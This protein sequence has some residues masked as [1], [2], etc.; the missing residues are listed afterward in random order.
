MAR[1]IRA[2]NKL[3]PSDIKF[4]DLCWEQFDMGSAMSREHMW[5]LSYP[6]LLLRASFGTADSREAVEK[7]LP[8]VQQMKKLANTGELT[9]SGT[10]S[11]QAKKMANYFRTIRNHSIIILAAINQYSKQRNA[12]EALRTTVAKAIVDSH[13][14]LRITQAHDQAYLAFIKRGEVAKVMHSD[15]LQA[16]KL[17]REHL[18]HA[19]DLSLYCNK[20]ISD[21]A[22]TTLILET[23][24]EDFDTQLTECELQ[25]TKRHGA[26]G[27]MWKHY[28]MENVGVF[29]KPG[30]NYS[31]SYRAGEDKDLM[32]AYATILSCR[33][34]GQL[35]SRAI[36]NV[37]N[38][39]DGDINQIFFSTKGLTITYAAIIKIVHNA[40]QWAFGF[41]ENQHNGKNWLAKATTEYDALMALEGEARVN[42]D[43]I[44]EKGRAGDNIEKDTEQELERITAVTSI[45]MAAV[46][47][48][49]Q[50]VNAAAYLVD[51][52]VDKSL[53][54]NSECP[55]PSCGHISA[56]HA[57]INDRVICEKCGINKASVM[58]GIWVDKKDELSK[59]GNHPRDNPEQA[60][61]FPEQSKAP[62]ILPDI[63]RR[64]TPTRHV[65]INSRLYS[66]SDPDTTPTIPSTVPTGSAMKPPSPHYLGGMKI[67]NPGREFHH[68]GLYGEDGV[69]G[70]Y[71]HNISDWLRTPGRA[72]NVRA[73]EQSGGQR[74]RD[75]GSGSDQNH[76][77]DSR[78]SSQG[79][80]TNHSGNESDGGAGRHRG[81]RR[82][83]GGG[84]DGGPP[85]GRGPP[86][87]NGPQGPPDNDGESSDDED[88]G[89]NEAI[90]DTFIRSTDATADGMDGGVRSL[91]SKINAL[92]AEVIMEEQH[93]VR[94]LRAMNM[95][96]IDTSSHDTLMESPA[97]QQL[98]ENNLTTLNRLAKGLSR[99]VET[100]TDFKVDPMATDPA[101]AG[102]LM[103]RLRKVLDRASERVDYITTVTRGKDSMRARL[104]KQGESASSE[105]LKNLSDMKVVPWQRTGTHGQSF[106]LYMREFLHS[107]KIIAQTEVKFKRLKQA[108]SYET[109][110][111]TVIAT[112]D[113]LQYERALQ[114]LQSI[115]GDVRSVFVD[116]MI[117]FNKLPDAVSSQADLQRLHMAVRAFKENLKIYPQLQPR[118]HEEWFLCNI[119][120]RLSRTVQKEFMDGFSPFFADLH[121][122]DQKSWDYARFFLDVYS[123]AQLRRLREYKSLD[124]A[125]RVDM[126]QGKRQ[127]GQANGGGRANANWASGKKGR[128]NDGNP[129][130]A[131]TRTK[132]ETKKDQAKPKVK[133]NA[134]SK[135]QDT[136]KPGAGGKST[137]KA[138]AN[139][140]DQNRT[141]GKI[142]R[143]GNAK[144]NE[145]IV[146]RGNCEGFYCKLVVGARESPDKNLKAEVVKRLSNAGVCPGCGMLA[147]SG[148][149]HQCEP[150]T[151]VRRADGSEYTVNVKKAQCET[152]CNYM[153]G[154]NRV[155]LMRNLC[156][157]ARPKAKRRWIVGVIH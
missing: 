124:A 24:G 105:A 120:R 9:C 15:P 138:N 108:M 53:R 110:A 11:G 134:M 25:Y 42:L 76:G 38:T 2:L 100:G 136:N 29:S 16:A 43:Q 147:P 112:F 95:L 93:V 130:K 19:K 77:G 126:L 79:N 39:R 144:G 34:K 21:Q 113:P 109:E 101:I 59:K 55:D 91:F 60:A 153:H 50:G 65:R 54:N 111:A 3:I 26:E 4:H 89:N 123:P 40:E 145:C 27:M 17:V 140:F 56:S 74:D 115:F 118:V 48:E 103:N 133:A 10:S 20:F 37:F 132:K 151:T 98:T 28:L 135:N 35:G 149:R 141:K 85:P 157:C 57:P 97:I 73:G 6:V 155:N 94:R 92:V 67:E 49:A 36:R 47:N 150:E 142:I 125:T 81:H 156:P 14:V 116:V 137:Q 51:G 64:E 86:G 7:A 102:P 22:K 146:C 114:E 106:I 121:P 12:Y 119:W 70:P 31:F 32:A 80:P 45:Q 66:D 154:G 46:V 128:G 129:K 75:K 88:D 84:R 117:E 78:D 87:P 139:A 58:H 96:K 30:I 62:P 71:G 5:K 1:L 82:H 68:R 18:R 131:D 61:Q 69:T 148:Q 8:I 23:R 122:D 44:K 83:T 33:K 52:R 99:L 104:A 41:L 63:K 13:G 143:P 127:S 90:S 107:N 72:G 152:G